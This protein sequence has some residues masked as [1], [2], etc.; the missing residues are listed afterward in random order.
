MREH[1]TRH[2]IS[3]CCLADALLADEHEGMG[4][5][6]AAVGGKER[7]FSAAVTEELAGHSR[8]RCFVGVGVVRAHEVAPA[9]RTGA[10][11]GRSRALTACQTCLATVIFGALASIMTQRCGSPA[12]SLR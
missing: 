1:E 2:S 4:H 7:G 9:K 5:A 3:E 10:V 6:A 8:R 12:A 11:T